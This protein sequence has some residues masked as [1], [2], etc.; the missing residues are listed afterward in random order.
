MVILLIIG[1]I[2]IVAGV[3]LFK[4]AASYSS[5]ATDTLKDRTKDRAQ[6]QALH[7]AETNLLI[8]ATGAALAGIALIVFYLQS[9]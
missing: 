3:F 2:A 5:Q 8:Y 9:V 1:I 4:M 7:N 6:L